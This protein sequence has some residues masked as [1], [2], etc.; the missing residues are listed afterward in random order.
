MNYLKTVQMLVFSEKPRI[1]TDQ[2][3][4]YTDRS[5]L[6]RMNPLNPWFHAQR[7][8]R[9]RGSG[10]N[11]IIMDNP[12]HDPNLFRKA[13]TLQSPSFQSSSYHSGRSMVCHLQAELSR[14]VRS[15]GGARRHDRTYHRFAMGLTLQYGK[16][17]L[18]RK[19]KLKIGSVCLLPKNC[20]NPTFFPFYGLRRLLSPIQSGE[21]THRAIWRPD[22]EG[23][24]TRDAQFDLRSDHRLAS[25]VQPRANPLSSLTHPAEPPVSIAPRP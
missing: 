18:P 20:A 10:A 12:R 14:R 8:R 6:I 3:R 17:C 7:F 1:H 2:K 22:R 13:R 11:L 19:E 9:R 25:Q 24:M 4:I 23:D 21:P 16:Q 15:D 5:V